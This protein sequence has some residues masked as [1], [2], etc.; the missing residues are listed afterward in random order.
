MP[1]VSITL[2]TCSYS[3]HF[4]PDFTMCVYL[5]IT[6]FFSRA[7]ITYTVSMY[8]SV[9]LSLSLSTS[10]PWAAW[11]WWL[12]ISLSSLPYPVIPGPVFV[13]WSGKC[14]RYGGGVY[15]RLLYKLMASL[16]FH[17]SDNCYAQL[18]NSTADW[19]LHI[20]YNAYTVEKNFIV[21]LKGKLFFHN[22]G[23]RFNFT[24]TH[25]YNIFK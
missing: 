15:L 21:A 1:V 11:Y 13:P 6:Q 4:L 16:L 17:P 25:Q 8:V 19:V 5:V 7:L 3:P 24:V 2:L 22:F 14:L 12:C 23:I 18:S 10:V 20:Q 9:P